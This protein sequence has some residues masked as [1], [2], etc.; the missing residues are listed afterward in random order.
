MII[1]AIQNT[2]QLNW[3]DA[4]KYI[5]FKR[6]LTNMML[7]TLNTWYAKN[8]VNVTCI[9]SWIST[10]HAS[11]IWTACPSNK[12]GIKDCFEMQQKSRTK[13]QC[14]QFHEKDVMLNITE[15]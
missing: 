2:I 6:N 7:P 5:Q 10:V 9:V 11:W 1:Y 14:M 4:K 13:F 12:T 8:Q 15:Y 3:Y